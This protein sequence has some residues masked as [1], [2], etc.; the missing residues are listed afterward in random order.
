MSPGN[1]NTL[2]GLTKFI[3]NCLTPFDE[4][5]VVEI[6]VDKLNGMKNIKGF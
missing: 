2:M 6:G 1:V 5:L 4:Y 3:N